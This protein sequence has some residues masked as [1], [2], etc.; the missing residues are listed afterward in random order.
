MSS[1]ETAGPATTIDAWMDGTLVL[2]QPARGRGYRVN[3]DS[4]WLARF[5]CDAATSD[6]WVIDLG[7]GVGAV[8]L[9]LHRLRP[10]QAL[11]LVDNSAT[12]VELARANLERATPRVEGHAV[13][14]DVQEF[15]ETL[16][17]GHSPPWQ[18]A[19]FGSLLVVANP[20]FT[21]PWAGRRCG[22]TG[23]DT[24]RRGDVAPFLV[25]TARLMEGRAA[26]ACLCYPTPHL[27]D[28][29]ATARDLGLDAVRMRFVHL[30]ADRPARLA[31][32]EFRV[33]APARARAATGAAMGLSTVVQAPWF[34]ERSDMTAGANAHRGDDRA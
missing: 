31:L 27:V 26:A 22:Q 6:S 1:T 3:V 7:A 30:R 23:R 28:L 21:P 16:Q 10:V 24:A 18:P 14:Q 8:G 2:E 9:A 19:A 32:V 33:A 20:P 13:L 29:V 34:D 5:A 11:T 4:L 25:A 15:A 17:S 12:M